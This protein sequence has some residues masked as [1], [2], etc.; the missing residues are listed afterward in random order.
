[1]EVSFDNDEFESLFSKPVSSKVVLSNA[2]NRHDCK[3]EK[4]GM[5]PLSVLDERRTHLVGVLLVSL[6]SM[7]IVQRALTE[8]DDGCLSAKDCNSL[9]KIFP[10]TEE[11]SLLKKAKD[12]GAFLTHTEEFLFQLSQIPSLQIRTKV[13]LFKREFDERG[14]NILRPLN[15]VHKAVEDIENSKA[16]KAV[17]GV[18]LSLGNYMNGGTIR[19]QADGFLLDI[20]SKLPDTK[21]I[22]NETTFLQYAAHVAYYDA[23]ESRAIVSELKI[24]RDASKISL[25]EVSESLYG[26]RAEL[27]DL[28]EAVRCLKCDNTSTQKLLKYLGNFEDYAEKILNKLEELL[29]KRTDEFHR[30]LL[31][32]GY[33]KFEAD[34]LT[35]CDFFQELHHFAVEV[36]KLLAREESL[37]KEAEAQN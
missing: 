7:S 23:P 4:K 24:L 22:D 15:M 19:G 2:L 17:L 27:K 1:M 6:P 16:L 32:F 12:A 26:L 10:T 25:S 35:T 20:L 31:M 36:G 13:L 9:L 14:E 37:Q 18:I 28:S 34:S 11:Q 30:L 21:A 3:T 33:S 5:T 8:M 29:K